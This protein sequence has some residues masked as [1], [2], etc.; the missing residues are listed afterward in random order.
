MRIVITTWGS[1]GDLNPYLGLALGLRARGH[2]PVLATMP[3]YR[4]DVEREE[5]AFHPVGPDVGADA[6]DMVRRVMDPGRGTEYLIRELL[7]SRLEQSYEELAAAAA[8]ADFLVSHPVT[9]AAPLVAERLGLRWA[10]TV[11]APMSFFSRYDLPVIPQA[12]WLAHFRG[13]PGVGRLFVRLARTATRGWDEPVAQ[14]RRR[15]GLRPAGNAIYEGQFSPHLNLALFSRVLAR[16]RPDWPPRT[17]VTGPVF[18]DRSTGGDGLEPS[19]SRFLDEGAPPIVFT[20]GTAAVSVAGRFYAESV[21]AAQRLGRRAVLLVGSSPEN[22]P[23]G[24]LSPEIHVAHAAPFGAL[25][26][27]AAAVVHS[28]GAGS[29]AQALRS[30]RPQLIVPHAHDQAD[31]AF[32]ASALGVA[33][34]ILAGRY[35]SD[36]AAESLGDLLG[37]EAVVRR[38]TEVGTAV[39]AEAGVGVACRVLEQSL[40]A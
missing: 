18:Y 29:T 27:R 36:R 28:G 23:P 31:N 37:D 40:T 32:R 7:L 20:L 3:R 2:E 5:L 35:R 14:L 10:A 16:P 11:L 26:P 17:T 38:A 34:T 1:Y 4:A 25:L 24:P 19:L 13:V 22:R 21:R 6:V 15:L 33:R 30:G 9:Y 39:R 12:P 8:S